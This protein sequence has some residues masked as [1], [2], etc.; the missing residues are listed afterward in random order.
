MAASAR[1]AAI[2]FVSV[3]LNL[4][5]RFMTG[6]SHDDVRGGTDAR[7]LRGGLNLAAPG[8]GIA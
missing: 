2:K 5:E 4:G 1:L 3:T 7:E 8:G 6:D